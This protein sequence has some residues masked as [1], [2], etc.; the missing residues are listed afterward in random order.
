MSDKNALTK[1]RRRFPRVMAPIFY[2]SPRLLSAKRRV[3]NISSGG[4]RIFSDEKFKIGKR[5]EIEF[6]LPSGFSI[7]AIAQV[8]WIDELPPN[9]DSLFDVGLE[10]INLPPHALKELEA[11]LKESSK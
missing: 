1:D 5:L 4:F 7:T 9:S 10:F 11:V 6:F 3:T 2:R 8:V